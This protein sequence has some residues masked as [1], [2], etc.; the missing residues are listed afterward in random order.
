[1]WDACGLS[2]LDEKVSDQ[3]LGA[4]NSVSLGEGNGR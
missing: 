1:M 4:K 2:C 3:S